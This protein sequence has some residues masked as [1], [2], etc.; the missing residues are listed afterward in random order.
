MLIHLLRQSS[1]RDREKLV[2]L[3]GL[4]RSTRTAADVAWVRAQM[5]RHGSIDHARQ[6]A[7]A[8]AGAATHEF[9]QAYADL[10]P[11]RDRRF[12]EAIALWVLERA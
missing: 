7:H 9:Q 11:S 6:V 3:L 10:P 5:D 1:G 2:R 8:L 4:P 12:L